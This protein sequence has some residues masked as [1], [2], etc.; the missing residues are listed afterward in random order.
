MTYFLAA[1][2]VLSCFGFMFFL[3]FFCELL[4]LPI[5]LSL[6]LRGVRHRPTA[7]R[8][9]HSIGK[10]PES[11]EFLR[12]P[13]SQS[14]QHPFDQPEGGRQGHNSSRYLHTTPWITPAGLLFS[15]GLK[16]TACLAP[17]K[18]GIDGKGCC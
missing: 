15:L 18:C 8:T 12:T 9:R 4:P 6:L 1:G 10:K 2:F 13:S 3:S 5:W 17:E 14:H 7:N 16:H 11:V